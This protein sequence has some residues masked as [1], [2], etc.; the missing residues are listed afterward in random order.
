[1]VLGPGCL[2]QVE[3]KY[4]SDEDKKVE[5]LYLPNK[6]NKLKK[7]AEFISLRNKCKSF[8]GKFVII[9]IDESSNLTKYGLTV[10][11]KIG[12]AVK[13]NYLKRVFRT[14][15]R[16]NWKSIK[17]SISFEIIPKKKIFNHSFT[18]IEKDIKKILNK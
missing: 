8:H 11:K 9:N 15:I 7:R 13:R 2:H 17:K 12:N 6:S 14:I 4:S 16:N 1:M 5:K 18:E 10:S 3:K